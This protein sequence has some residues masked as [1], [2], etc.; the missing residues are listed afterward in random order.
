MKKRTIFQN[1]HTHTHKI[2]AVH[3]NL[4]VCVSFYFTTT[5]R[6]SCMKIQT[7]KGNCDQKLN[8]KM[9]SVRGQETLNL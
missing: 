3:F 8:G 1:I 6:N 9:E 2:I 5:E 4:N 7:K